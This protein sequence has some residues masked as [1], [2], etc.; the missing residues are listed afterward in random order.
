MP[1]RLR[2]PNLVLDLELVSPSCATGSA[3]ARR[4]RRSAAAPAKSRPASST[5]TARSPTRASPR[6]CSPSSSRSR[7][8]SARASRPC[9]CSRSCSDRSPRAGRSGYRK[10]LAGGVL[11]ALAATAVTWVL[12]TVVLDI[13]PV[14][15]ELLEGADG[16]RSRSSSS[17][18]QL[19]ARLATR[20]QATARVHA[21]A[22]RRGDLGR[23][24]GGL[25]RRS[26]SRPS[27][28]RA[29][30]PC[31]STRR[32]RSSRRGSSSGW[33]S[34]SSRPR[35]RSAAVAYAIL[36]LGKQLPLKPMLI[37][38]R[39]D[40]APALGRLR[41]QRRPLAAGAPTDLDHAGRRAGRACRSSSP[42]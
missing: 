23:Q 39:V 15:R 18:R 10:P 3:T 14:Q 1:L 25:R 29:S 35:S 19:L 33:C 12:A 5:S 42:S 22:G 34:A 6:P 41:R 4:C 27:T 17:S 13:A 26:A 31:S 2:D 16:A 11:A 20:A 38:G 21:G 37:G 40:P 28:A 30:R 24:R 7:S 8:S 32:S 9:S 36:K